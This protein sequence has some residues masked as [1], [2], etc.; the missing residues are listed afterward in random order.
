MN[1]KA[2]KV[3]L[4]DD[5]FTEEKEGFE[6]ILN[7]PSRRAEAVLVPDRP[8]EISG[9]RGDSMCSIVRD[10]DTFK[11]WYSVQF[12]EGAEGKLPADWDRIVASGRWDA[13]TLA[14]LRAAAA[15]TRYAL[16]YATS[17]D[18]VHWEKPELGRIEWNGSTQNNIVLVD[19]LACSVFLDPNGPEDQRFKMILGSGPRLP[20]YHLVET[21]EPQNMYHG[22]YGATSPDGIHWQRTEKPIV[23][24]YTDTTNVAYWDDQ[25]GKYVA[26]VRDNEGM[27]YEDGRTVTPD[28]GF[29]LRYRCIGRTESE[30]FF[31]F[32]RPTRV[33]A[34]T[35]EQR[36]T[37]SE[38]G[39]F[40]KG[41][42]FYNS[43]AL[44]Y[45]LAP[46]AY[47]LFSSDFYHEPDTLDVHLYTSR[48]GVSY[49]RWETPYLG[50]GL[51]GRFDSHTIYLAAG[52]APAGDRLYQYY[53]GQDYGHAD[54]RNSAHYSGGIGLAEVRPDGFVSQ[55]AGQEGGR[56]RT[57]PL[58]ASGRRIQ[59]N[60]DANAGGWLKVA[61]LDEQGNPI[62][63]RSLAEADSLR[64]N[65]LSRTATWKGNADVGDARHAP[66]C[67]EFT[68]CN[69]K[70][71][72]FSFE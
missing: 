9:L 68:G 61:L 60:M 46:D 15:G 56:L 47:F 50:L 52:I 48:D 71:Y 34:P 36:G 8:W 25:T 18:G 70:L 31:N 29:R 67:L 65:T 66:V 27:V 43:A 62:P 37:P 3:L 45:P 69:I 11:L 20:H 35:E 44:K 16:C 10:G 2:A 24:W 5:A 58:T 30:D 12:M 64:G 21:V 38:I 17:T 39:Y 28:K 57:R 32:P 40:D 26:F 41:L 7:P 72:S 22:I 13:K 19:R 63:G 42:D 4:F 1:T 23:P 55:D 54:V 59:I 33:A 53:V 51:E 49:E 14:D 6:A